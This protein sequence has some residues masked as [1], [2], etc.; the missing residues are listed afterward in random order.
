[1][2]KSSSA[3]GALSGTA[4]RGK[5]SRAK[6]T[7]MG[8][9]SPGDK[10]GGSIA[11]YMVLI[12]HVDDIDRYR[13]EY[14]PRLSRSW[15]STAE[16]SLVAGFEAEAADGEPPNSTVVLRFPD[17][18]AAGIPRRPGLPAVQRAPIQHHV[19]RTGGGCARVHAAG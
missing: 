15:R 14:V 11:A 8:A 19:A 7:M 9:V 13:N 5:L 6:P 2:E 1:M 17:A 3:P 18:E 12:Q 16:E 4:V 10:R